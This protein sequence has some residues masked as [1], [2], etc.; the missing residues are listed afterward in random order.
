M[1]EKLQN[2]RQSKGLDWRIW[3]GL[4]LTV[5]YLA[6][7]LYHITADV[8][9]SAFS[10]QSLE[11]Q[12]SFLEGAFAPL[13]FLW[14]VIGYFLQ[15]KALQENNR[16]IELQ[17]RAMRRT[18]EHAAVQA[19]AIAA[20]ERHSRQ[21]SFLEV[22]DL[23]SN[24]PGVTAGLLYIANQRSTGVA[25]DAASELW[26]K[27][28]DGDAG[29]F[30]RM[31]LDLCFSPTGRRPDGWRVFFGTSVRR[32]HTE[33]FLTTFKALLDAARNSDTNGLLVNSVIAGT[34]HGHL[35]N[36]IVDYRRERTEPVE[37]VIPM[38]TTDA[39]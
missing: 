2:G 28:S 12:G 17:Y 14:L 9:W 33:Q 23:V 20:S 1:T 32:R 6:Y 26:S 29:L 22:L 18:A 37:V 3:F 30:S 21:G 16:N 15:H 11:S 35:Y 10:Q 19:D 34:A 5:T 36:A 27:L 31:L 39:A 13:A 4:V 7:G 8:G 25:V 38:E 24:Q